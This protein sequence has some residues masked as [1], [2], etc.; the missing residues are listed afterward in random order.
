MA[1]KAIN[2]LVGPN[3]IVLTLLVFDAYPRLTEID[4]L[5]LSITK[6]VEAIRIATKEVRCLYAER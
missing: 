1:I 3:D 2:D 5:S 4:P 6:R